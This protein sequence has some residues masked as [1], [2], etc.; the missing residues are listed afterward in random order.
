MYYSVCILDIR[1]FY[2]VYKQNVFQTFN[3]FI[4][5]QQVLCIADFTLNQP[6]FKQ[7]IV[8]SLKQQN[9]FSF[10]MIAALINNKN[11]TASS[12]D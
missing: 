12:E 9:H 10:A 5:F 4:F 6:W 3:I 8:L 1:H 7:S 2:M 11:E